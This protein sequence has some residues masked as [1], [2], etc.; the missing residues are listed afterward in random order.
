MIAGLS[1][2]LAVMLLTEPD[3]VIDAAAAAASITS[4]GSVSSI[5]AKIAE[6][7]EITV[8]LRT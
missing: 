1:A 5:T 4:S 6:R 8:H 7:P 3:E 2:I